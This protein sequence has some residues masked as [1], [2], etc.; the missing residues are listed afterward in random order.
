MSCSQRRI[1]PGCLNSLLWLSVKLFSASGR[2]MH[3]HP[4]T[5]ELQVKVLSRT[6]QSSRSQVSQLRCA[7]LSVLLQN[8]IGRST[9][10]FPFSSAST[11]PSNPQPSVAQ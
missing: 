11:R 3:Q 2:M 10:S 6:A 9:T 8:A 5:I 1:F 7:A 4:P